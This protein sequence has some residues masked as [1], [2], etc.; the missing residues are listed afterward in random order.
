MTNREKY[1]EVFCKVFSIDEETAN[2]LS[3]QGI[4]TWDSVGHMELIAELENKF[5]IMMDA[6]DIIELSSFEKGMD[7]LTQNYSIEF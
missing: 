2:G 3:Y 7:I 5:S 1:V 4:D 6:D